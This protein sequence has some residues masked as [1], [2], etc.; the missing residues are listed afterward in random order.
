M[1][2]NIM[3]ENCTESSSKKAPLWS[4]SP[5]GKRIK[6]NEDI[7]ISAANKKELWKC[8]MK[9]TTSA[10]TDTTPHIAKEK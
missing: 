10:Y 7:N 2:E 6:N 1:N 3:V 9:L 8:Y 5:N 4:H